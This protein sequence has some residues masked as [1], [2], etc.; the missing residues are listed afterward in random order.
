MKKREIIISGTKEEK[1]ELIKKEISGKNCMF[2][3]IALI[4][5][6]KELISDINT[7]K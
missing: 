6:A 1:L 5:K 3:N 4:L 2:T 7:L